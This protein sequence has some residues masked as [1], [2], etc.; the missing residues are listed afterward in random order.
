[1][2]EFLEIE[3]RLRKAGGGSDPDAI[4]RKTD[5]LINTIEKLKQEMKEGVKEH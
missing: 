3:S 5:S 1:M 4:R 2:D